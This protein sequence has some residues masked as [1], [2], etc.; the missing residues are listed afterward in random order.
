MLQTESM[1]RFSVR[2]QFGKSFATSFIKR[3]NGAW[4]LDRILLFKMASLRSLIVHRLASERLVLHCR[5]T[6]LLLLLLLQHFRPFTIGSGRVKLVT[7]RK[8]RV[9]KVWV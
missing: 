9:K 6:S 5:A 4:I 8:R 2:F 1:H 7:S 3:T